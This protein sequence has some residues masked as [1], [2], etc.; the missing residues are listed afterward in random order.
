MQRSSKA[1][2]SF[3]SVM[4][5]LFLLER[6][7]E[8]FADQVNGDHSAG[9]PKAMGVTSCSLRRNDKEAEYILILSE[10]FA[11]Q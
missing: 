10:Q 6:N 5:I 3:T 1:L 11:V 8:I 4:E 9:Y 7:T 2:S